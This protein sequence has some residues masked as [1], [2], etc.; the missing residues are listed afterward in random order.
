MTGSYKRFRKSDS[1]EY[2]CQKTTDRNI[3]LK[4]ET[5]IKF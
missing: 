1:M 4:Q 5:K 2:K 3:I